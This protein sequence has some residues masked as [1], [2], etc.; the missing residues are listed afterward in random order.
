ME[1][2]ETDM[3]HACPGSFSLEAAELHSLLSW[4]GLRHW[5]HIIQ[6]IG[7]LFYFF[8][9]LIWPFIKKEFKRQW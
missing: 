3:K 1:D 5:L 9:S 7:E 2:K 8:L 6:T 4:L